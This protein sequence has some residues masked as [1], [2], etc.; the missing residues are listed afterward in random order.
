MGELWDEHDVFYYD[1]FRSADGDQVPIRVRSVVGLISL[2][3]TMTLGAETLRVLPNFAA[4]MEWFL[5]NRTEYADVDSNVH[6]VA[7]NEGHLLAVVSPE[8][9]QRLLSVMLDEAEF[10]S[11]HGIRALSARHRSQPFTMQLGGVTATVDYEPGESTGPLFGGNSNWRGPVWFP[12][13]YL[14][15]DALRRYSAYFGAD[16]TSEYPTGSGEHRDLAAIAD[17]LA[18]RLVSIFRDD[19]SARRPV[20]GQ[21]DRFQSDASW[22]DLLF[23]HEYFHGDTGAGLGA[24]HQTGWTGL[25]ADLLS[26]RRDRPRSR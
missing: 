12:V 25:V 19:A 9:L 3:A 5:Q 16:F 23:F 20:F 6:T 1:V 10:L 17:D 4:R 18:D 26:A 22:H 7:G 24:S 14:L 11:P 21:Y 2:C 15:I 8:R 13:N